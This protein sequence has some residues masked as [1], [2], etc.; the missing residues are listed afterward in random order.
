MTPEERL[1]KLTERVDAIARNLELLSH[2]QVESEQRLQRF[3]DA[4]DDRF[5]RHA[6]VI[7]DHGDR[8]D[9]L[10]GR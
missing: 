2:L 8:L 4:A 1:E 6:N 9:S 5:T 3:I 10:E 7:A